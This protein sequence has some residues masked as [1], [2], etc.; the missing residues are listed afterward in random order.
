MNRVNFFIIGAAKSGTTY[1]ARNLS[2]HKNIFIPTQEPVFFSNDLSDLTVFNNIN[3]KK[4]F[5]SDN[6]SE[7]CKIFSNSEYLK[8]QFKD[9]I[10]ELEKIIN[11]NLQHWYN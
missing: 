5:E 2:K 10:I 1:L 3:Q 4:E 7:R 8:G 11:K 6:I 9:Q